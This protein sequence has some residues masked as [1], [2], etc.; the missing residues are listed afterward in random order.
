MGVEEF[1][2]LNRIAVR[3]VSKYPCILHAELLCL[4]R[5]AGIRT[6]GELAGSCDRQV[7]RASQSPQFQVR[8]H[9]DRRASAELDITRRDR[10]GIDVSGD[11]ITG[12]DL[13]SLKGQEQKNHCKCRYKMMQ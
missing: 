8:V 1:R 12:M 11:G 7:I 9:V 10:A 5:G 2:D 13:H 6:D 4:D 3:G